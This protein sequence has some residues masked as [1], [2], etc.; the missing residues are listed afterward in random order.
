[1]Y[2]GS[3]ALWITAASLVWAFSVEKYVDASGKVDEPTGE[4]T[5]GLVRYVC[6][7][8]ILHKA[9][10]SHTPSRS[11]PAPFKCAFKP[12]SDKVAELVRVVNEHHD[13]A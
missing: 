8:S 7:D 9:A 2:M 5:Y 6:V 12:R 1:M 13:D 11:Y 4:F 10:H 3:D